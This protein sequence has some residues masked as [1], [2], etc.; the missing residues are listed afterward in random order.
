VHVLKVDNHGV[1]LNREMQCNSQI[2]QFYTFLLEKQNSVDG[3]Q[4]E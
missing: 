1:K 2:C 4:C 3:V